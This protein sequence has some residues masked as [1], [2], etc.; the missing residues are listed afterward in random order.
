[1]GE[2]RES[3][4]SGTSHAP[5]PRRLR[6]YDVEATDALIDELSAGR[7]RL[8]SE[9]VVLRQQVANLEAALDRVRQRVSKA[10]IAASTHARVVHDRAQQEAELILRRARAQADKLTEG[11]GRIDREW[12]EA[13]PELPLQTLSSR[14]QG[15]E[16][17]F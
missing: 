2:E 5:L 16:S 17:G 1:M 9:C 4:F 14:H 8:E 11:V 10:L 3:R 7:R 6:G 13:E 15:V 12:D